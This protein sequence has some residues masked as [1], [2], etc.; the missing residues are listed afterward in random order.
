MKI[1]HWHK[2]VASLA[3]IL[4]IGGGVLP[5][6][7]TPPTSTMQLAQ[8]TLVG[9][10]RAA[11]TRIFVYSQR[12]TTSPTLRTLAPTDPVTLA[13]NGNAGFIAISS[14]VVGYVQA[15]DLTACSA[16]SDTAN[17]PPTP[18]TGRLCRN[19]I[20]KTGAGLVIRSSPIVSTTN[21]VGS[22]AQNA[23]VSL[24][25]PRERRLESSGG[26]TWERIVAPTPGWVSSGYPEGNL[27]NPYN[28]P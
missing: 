26:R 1:G 11:K 10:C 9:Q 13:D 16:N 20:P 24:T 22:V 19:V 4:G 18:A 23:R 8:A 27:S 15:R 21:T 3:V 17:R 6:I 5:A 12:S 14:P 7:A 28:C 25:N 2:P